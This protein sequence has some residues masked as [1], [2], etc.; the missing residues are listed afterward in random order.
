MQDLEVY[1]HKKKDIRKYLQYLDA[2]CKLAYGP[3]NKYVYPKKNPYDAYTDVDDFKKRIIGDKLITNH[4]NTKTCKFISDALPTKDKK[5]RYYS[6]IQNERECELVKGVW[7]DRTLNRE[8]KYDIGVCW[9]KEQ[10]KVCSSQLKTLDMLRPGRTKYNK[11]ISKLVIDESN[12]CNKTIGCKWEQQTAYTYDCIK[13]DNIIKEEDKGPVMTPP[14]KMPLEEFEV[15]L[16]DWYIKGKYGKAPEVG[17]LKGRGDRCNNVGIEE[18]EDDTMSLPPAP[19]EL[20][21]YVSFR[22]L[23]PTNIKDIVVLKQYMTDDFFKRFKE[24]WLMLKKLGPI[25]YKKHIDVDEDGI[26]I[27][28]KF[29]DRMDKIQFDK[30]YSVKGVKKV[31]E[32]TIPKKMVPSIPQSIVNMVM[33]NIAIKNSKK[34]GLL[35]WHSTGSGKCHALNTPILMHDGSIKKVQDI[36]IGDFIM[37]DDSTLRK[38]LSLGRGTDDMYDIIPVKGEKYTVNSEH[39]LCLKHT[40]KTSVTHIPRQKNLPYKVVHIDKNIIK[41]KTKLFATKEE[42]RKYMETFTEEDK[43]VEVSVKN[44]LNLAKHLKTNLKGYRKGVEFA[45]RDVDFDP[46]IIGVW[47]GDGASNESQITNQDSKILFYLRRELKKYNLNLT[48]KSKYDYYIGANTSNRI[49][50]MMNAL[51]KYNLIKNKHIPDDYKINNRITRLKVLAGLIDTDGYLDN[52]CY[53]IIQKNKRLSDDILFIARSLGFAAYQTPCN[54][55]IVHKNVKITGLYY[56]VYISGEG[57]EDIPVQITRNKAHKRLQIKDALVTNIKVEYV[58]KG[59]YYGFT[60][61]GNHKYLMG[62]FTVTHNTNTATGVMDAFW[63]NEKQ[64]IF[65]SSIDAIASNP[66]FVFHRCAYNFFPRFQQGVFVGNDKA[67]SLALIGAAFKKRNIRFLSFAKLS[68]RV[69]KANEYKKLNKL[70]GG[71][72]KERREKTHDEILANDDYVDLDKCILIIDEVHLL[73]DPLPN[74]KTQHEYLE[75]QLIDVKKYPNMKLVILTATPG[76]NIQD[77][78][79]LLNIVRDHDKSEIKPPNIENKVDIERFSNEIRGMISYL[80]MSSDTTKFPILT[81]S[82]PKKY[83]MSNYQYEKVLDA[84][85]KMK[86]IQKNYTALVKSNQISKYYEPV[87]KYMNMLFSFEKDMNMNDFSSK[88]P[89]L[90]ENIELYPNQKQ[91]VYS[92]FYTRAGYGGH[93]IVAIAKELEKKGYKKLTIAE[94]KKYNKAGK[95][96]E[97]GI[98]R[99]ILAI[100]TELGEELGNSGYNLAELLKI[101]N[102]AENKYGDIIHVMLA[103]N[104]YNTGIDLKAVRHIH[105][106]EPAISM[107]SDL[108]TLGRAR[109]FCSHSHLNRALGEWTVDIHRYMSDL[110]VIKV[111]DISELR[112]QLQEEIVELDVK[113]A[114][115]GNKDMIKTAKKAVKDKEKEIIKVE[116]GK[117]NKTDLSQLQKELK[118]LEKAFDNIEADID[119]AKE[120]IAKLKLQKS[121]KNK[122]LKKLDAPVKGKLDQVE[123]IE[124]LIFNESRERF[125]ELFTIYNCMRNMSIDCRLLKDFHSST[126]G[127]DI[128]CV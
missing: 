8:N 107:A 78:M 32:A 48:F 33:K 71:G 45:H 52:N 119:N 68:N 113:I 13:G 116:K 26:D 22:N 23:N 122:A 101:Y 59:K 127:Q 6:K 62:D 65:A 12:K 55:S 47:L 46:Y 79:K 24:K 34:R 98:K 15:F 64:I 28:E 63:D 1:E 96:P 50:P 2:K 49:N 57:L 19:L 66:D 121:K 51:R 124:E 61:D 85:K 53:E 72:A 100:N 40:F 81:D 21:A 110:P 39:I 11:N 90:L 36:K 54:K 108:Q 29:Y 17:K 104:K 82:E 93:G 128:T 14:D 95:L 125:K 18:L 58:G 67:H 44:Y 9:V 111:A 89:K 10:D 25:R 37:G 69:L 80:D 38:V 3:L 91:Y 123:N 35:C 42:A 86:D 76:D 94:A 126:S 109:R 77:I 120:V 97:K 102:H 106:F 7:D 20:P 41:L 73:F 56:R 118:D 5:E 114:N 92:T 30:D 105:I 16:E 84:Y 83:P 115:I 74:Q 99:Y 4:I 31:M 27:M 75:K 112:K 103:S 117:A 43:L 87:R 60:L 88:L 70:N